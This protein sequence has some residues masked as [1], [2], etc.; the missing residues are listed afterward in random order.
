VQRILQYRDVKPWNF[1]ENK[2]QVY[3]LMESSRVQNLRLPKVVL[4]AIHLL[5]LVN[6]WERSVLACFVSLRFCVVINMAA[7][8]HENWWRHMNVTERPTHRG[9]CMDPMVMLGYCRRILVWIPMFFCS[10]F[11]FLFIPENVNYL[12][13]V[14][15]HTSHH[16]CKSPPM[17]IFS[18]CFCE[19][20]SLCE[21]FSDE[22]QS[23]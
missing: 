4:C 6:N 15:L 11:S 8:H 22:V 7:P 9:T 14:R 12:L 1:H 21:H 2:W 13:A 20:N 10:I 17:C 23:V 19:Q 5:H 16:I 18:T 3:M